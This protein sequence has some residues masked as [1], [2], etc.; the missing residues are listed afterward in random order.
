MRDI[1]IHDIVMDSVDSPFRFDLNWYPSFSYPVIPDS[2]PIQSI[3]TIGI[4]WPVRVDPPERGIPEFR[5][6]NSRK[7]F[8]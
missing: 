7:Y 1:Y 3:K 6:H 5:K 8:C 2:I 4:Q